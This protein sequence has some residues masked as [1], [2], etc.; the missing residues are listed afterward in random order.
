ML[1]S[2]LLV[3]VA[4][5]VLPKVLTSGDT[6]EQVSPANPETTQTPPGTSEGDDTTTD[7]APDGSV[8]ENPA[9][10]TNEQSS[11]SA[12]LALRSDSSRSA[13]KVL[14]E[15]PWLLNDTL[16]SDLVLPGAEKG[17]SLWAL[18]RD[19]SS[20]DEFAD[21]YVS[22]YEFAGEVTVEERSA[23]VRRL[24]FTGQAQGTKFEARIRVLDVGGNAVSVAG[25]VLTDA[26]PGP[27]VNE[28]KRPVQ[29]N[30]AAAPGTEPAAPEGPATDPASP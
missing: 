15:V 20:F 28:P 14:G 19:V 3:P 24:L 13:L 10:P 23:G 12:P 26:V 16:T 11:S 4:L 2:L 17:Y 29:Q 7:D 6:A 27:V 8:T 22:L 30:P 21:R 18:H 5:V 9:G 1:A 25:V